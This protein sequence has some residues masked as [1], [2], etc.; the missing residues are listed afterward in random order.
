MIING[1]MLTSQQIVGK[2]ANN[3]IE[4]YDLEKCLSPASY[5]VRIGS[6]HNWRLNKR[7]ALKE[8]EKVVVEPRHPLLLGTKEKFV[9]PN[10]LVGMMYLRSS[11]ARR[12]LLSWFQGMIN[13]GFEGHLTIVLHNMTAHLIELLGE[14][15]ICHLVFHQLSEADL[16]GYTG[17]YQGSKGADPAS[18]LVLGD[19]A[20][21][22]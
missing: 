1:A 14:E 7:I 3:L 12:G 17:S 19:R 5:E 4:N 18:E 10:D 6:Y 15:N 9:F 13:P 22:K 16:K 8:N 21:M 20:S 11:F 2:I